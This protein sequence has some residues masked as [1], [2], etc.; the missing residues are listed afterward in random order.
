MGFTFISECLVF[1]IKIK[2]SV[3]NRT[4]GQDAG[5]KAIFLHFVRFLSE[6]TQEVCCD[7]T[8][9]STHPERLSKRSINTS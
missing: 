2:L 6:S 8:Q 5:M 7:R 3:L 4:P 1:K 9:Q